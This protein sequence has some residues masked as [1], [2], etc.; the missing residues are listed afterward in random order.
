[1]NKYN[2]SIRKH[3]EDGICLPVDSLVAMSHVDNCIFFTARSN[4]VHLNFSLYIYIF[5]T[6]M[7]YY[8]I[9]CDPLWEKVQKLNLRYA[10]K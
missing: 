8:F 10:H 1:M 5:Y 4:C 2:C 6:Y 9:I 7:S 3:V